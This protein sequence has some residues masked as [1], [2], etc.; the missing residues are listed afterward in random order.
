[1]IRMILFLTL[2]SM[3]SCT[4]LPTA[5]VQRTPA[6]AAASAPI[7]Q[8]LP[9]VSG[10]EFNWPNLK[11]AIINNSV[12]SVD[13]ALCL[14]PPE[15]RS[16]VGLMVSSVSLQ[17]STTA[18]PRVILSSPYANQTVGE[19]LFFSF[20]GTGDAGGDEIEVMRYRP[21]QPPSHLLEMIE[22]KLDGAHQIQEGTPVRCQKCH[23]IE[24]QFLW[25]QRDFWPAA[26]NG[27]SVSRTKEEW[28]HVN[29]LMAKNP[30]YA[31][32]NGNG[33][34]TV[35]ARGSLS[36][37]NFYAAE[38]N[39]HRLVGKVQQSPNYREY[40]Y[41]IL[42][43]LLGCYQ[44]EGFLPK[45]LIPNHQ[46]VSFVQETH[47]NKAAAIYTM[48]MNRVAAGV[49]AENASMMKP[50]YTLLDSIVGATP[51]SMQ[52]PKWQQQLHLSKQEPSPFHGSK[53]FALYTGDMIRIEKNKLLFG[54]R[55]DDNF[56]LEVVT[57]PTG[58]NLRYLFEGR[59]IGISDWSYDDI[60][61]TYHFGL[62]NMSFYPFSLA[63]LLVGADADLRTPEIEAF[64][65]VDPEDRGKDLQFPGTERKR[66]L[67]GSLRQKSL[68][69]LASLTRPTTFNLDDHRA[70]AEQNWAHHFSNMGKLSELPENLPTNPKSTRNCTQCHFNYPANYTGPEFT[71]QTKNHPLALM[72]CANCHGDSASHVAPQIPFHDEM[73]LRQFIKSNPGFSFYAESRLSDDAKATLTHM[74]PIL[75]LKDGQRKVVLDYLKS[76]EN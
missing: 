53:S 36:T 60:Q 17:R 1:M 30:R 5:E 44:I 59:G 67:C 2:F 55:P 3:L 28:V 25:S 27:E 24:P 71:R 58:A 14:V 26:A 45:A 70:R 72:I 10:S 65:R 18:Q 15:V 33:Q 6:Q 32:L 13:K 76:L 19:R 12:D 20:N 11:A 73:A 37:I 62:E 52:L 42:G 50:A 49:T 39:N 38:V 63:A 16:D 48:A 69:S 23:G 43:A 64:F 74:P 40:K 4:A 29:Q 34:Y 8:N 7:C 68:T 66:V 41:A 31:F 22:L 61:G 9:V 75:L 56:P 57:D 51:I 35:G 21:A 46:N 47:W 54:M